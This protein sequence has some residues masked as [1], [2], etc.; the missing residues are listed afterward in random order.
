MNS[1][2]NREPKKVSLPD[3]TLTVAELAS[4]LEVLA[5]EYH[6]NLPAIIRKLDKVSGNLTH[7][8]ETMSGDNSHEWSPEEDDMLKTHESLLV[9][10]KGK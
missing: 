6:T 7:L 8:E 4:C 5:K 2:E 3:S 10:W 1:R 9:R